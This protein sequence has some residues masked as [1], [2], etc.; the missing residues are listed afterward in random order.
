MN[1]YVKLIKNSGIFFIGNFGSKLLS[2]LLVPY[3]THV[4]STEEYG[5]ADIIQTTVIMLMP[6]LTFSIAEASLRFAMDKA[7][8]KGSVLTNS[9]AVLFA[10]SIV[11]LAFC[12]LLNLIPILGEYL[13]VFY[14]SMVTCGFNL[15][16]S[17]YCRGAGHV[18]AYAIGGIISTGALVFSNILLLLY[19]KLGV[20]GYLI[21]TIASYVVPS[22]YYCFVIKINKVMGSI[23]RGLIREMLAYSIPLIPNSI[24]WWAMTGANKYIL[25]YTVGQAANGLF[26]VAQKLPS[27]VNII[28]SVFMQSWQISAVDESESK[29]KAKFYSDIFNVLAMTMLLATS[30]LTAV[31]KPLYSV[32]LASE[33]YEAWKYTTILMLANVFS[34]FSTF[35]G[36][37]YIAMKKT[38]G[39]LKTALVGGLVNIIISVLAISK[40][41]IYAAA[42]STMVAFLITW[43]Y[44]M[45]DTKRFITLSTNYI[46]IVTVLGIIVIQF[47]ALMLSDSLWVQAILLALAVAIYIKDIKLL[48]KNV[49]FKKSKS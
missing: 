13:L 14:I 3:Y 31:V 8:D 20:T 24:F 22:I 40:F 27:I 26:V 18:K 44:R 12:P 15:I 48:L 2:F 6:L 4:L 5:T 30:F 35:V 43:I 38:S 28:S 25:V 19:F 9:L 46:K 1:K 34:C 37:N 17:Q 49:F 7:A 16:L 10:G 47:V 11:L 21:S 32:W 36:V 45:Y 33:Y 42:I 41:G 23:D 29:D 39:N